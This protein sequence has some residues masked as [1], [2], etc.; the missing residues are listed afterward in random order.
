VISSEVIEHVFSPRGFAESVAR[1]ARPGGHVLLT[2][3]GYEGFDILNLQELSNSIFPPHHINFL[4]IK[5]FERLFSDCGMTDIEVRTPGRLDVDI[6]LN[7]GHG[8]E[9]MRVLAERGEEAVADLQALLVKHKLSS[10][11]WAF[12][13]K[14]E[15]V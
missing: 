5:G 14:G 4:S 11:I 8:G 10:H 15:A 9:F 1:L 12:A 13:R 2:G 7:S 3:L 6:V